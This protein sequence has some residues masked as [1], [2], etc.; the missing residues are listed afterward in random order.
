VTDV[1][2]CRLLLTGFEPFDRF[3]VNPS[4]EA[5]RAVGDALG[6]AV[7]AVRLPVDYLPARERL[8]AALETHRPAACLCMGLAPSDE[9]RME[10]S[11][12]KPPQFDAL[13]GEALL[14]CEWDWESTGK[15]LSSS[16][17]PHRPSTDAGRYVCESTYWAL[18]DFRRRTGRPARAG[19]LHV[20]AAS[21]LFPVDRTTA[22]VRGVVEQ[23]L[24]AARLRPPLHE[25]GSD[26]CEC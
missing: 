17:V 23:F 22:C 8:I 13:P 16:G 18:L 1:T 9:F 24:G 25:P 14:L 26:S 10:L 12:R 7:V 19:F 4:W 15:T 20:P 21:A 5:A 6:P 11:A 3:D 2:G